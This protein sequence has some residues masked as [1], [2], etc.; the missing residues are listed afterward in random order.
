[1]L[2]PCLSFPRFSLARSAALPTK[3]WLLI[4]LFGSSLKY[5]SGYYTLR[6]RQC[7][8]FLTV[9]QLCVV[10]YWIISHLQASIQMEQL[11]DMQLVTRDHEKTLLHFKGP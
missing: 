3:H 6:M 4:Q 1:M 10:K 9:L 11:T 8:F 5:N 7:L 2:G